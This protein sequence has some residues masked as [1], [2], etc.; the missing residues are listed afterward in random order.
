MNR[1]NLRLVQLA[2][3]VLLTAGISRAESTTAVKIGGTGFGL[4]LM[5]IMAKDYQQ[6][7]PKVAIIVFP[8]LGSSG[9]IK[10]LL[11]GELDLAISSRPLRQEEQGQA[12]QG[13]ELFKTPF[14]FITNSAVGKG[15]ITTRELEQIY[16]GRLLSWPDGSRIRVV[17]RPRT[18]TDTEIVRGLS[19]GMNAA[20][21]AA[22]AHPG[23]IL[24]ITDQ[25]NLETMEKT[26]GALGGGTLAQILS[27]QRRVVI[28]KLNGQ[29]PSVE[30]LQ[31]GSYTLAKTLY[32]M[33]RK[34]TS[35]ATRQFISFIHS[36]KGQ[37]IMAAYGNLVKPALGPGHE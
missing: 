32:L 13:S 9:G 4:E 37:E 35:A 26:P 22:M 27:E 14:V 6:N 21:S 19:P 24:S 16:S 31:D 28:L 15:S 30:A 34:E 29:K 18:E 10:A 23:M 36:G 25:E 8:S 17:L 3:A 11:A 20:V 7:Q 2:L 5:R 33:T 1:I 12:L